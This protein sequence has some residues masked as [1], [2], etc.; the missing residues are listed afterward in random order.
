MGL[1]YHLAYIWHH[2]TN[3]DTVVRVTNT[4]EYPC[5]G[6]G[7]STTVTLRIMISTHQRLIHHLALRYSKYTKKRN[8]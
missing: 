6:G 7:Q 3:L 1:L 4:P 5:Q 8:R 2:F